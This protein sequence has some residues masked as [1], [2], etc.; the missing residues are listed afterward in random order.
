MACLSLITAKSS[1]CPSNAWKEYIYHELHR[2]NMTMINI[3]ANSGSNVNE[4]LLKHDPNW[5][6]SPSVWHKNA[7]MGCGACKTK[8]IKGTR[9]VQ[10]IR[11]IAIELLVANF[12]SL[13]RVFNRFNVPGIALNAAGGSEMGMTAAPRNTHIG[14]ESIGIARKS[15]FTVDVP[16]VNV[17]GIVSMFGWTSP[18][19][20]LS[21]D[22]EG[23]D[24]IVLT[25]AQNGLKNKQ[26]RIVEFE[27]HGVGAWRNMRLNITVSNLVAYGYTCFWQGKKNCQ[28]MSQIA[29][30]SFAGGLISS[31]HTN[32][33]LL[34]D[35]FSFPLENIELR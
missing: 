33:L 10:S 34:P 32:R 1:Q 15:K 11:V 13:S 30:T 22:T 24:A 35:L 5:N 16:M 2:D 21:I 6:V 23:N 12:I 28:G 25:G 27:Y 3:G 29:Q 18:I 19:D 26:F 17:D 9:P 31:V 7:N 8:I 14:A 4:F 20:F